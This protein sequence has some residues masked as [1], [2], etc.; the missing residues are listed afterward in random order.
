MDIFEKGTVLLTRVTNSDFKS[1]VCQKK[2]KNPT[3]ETAS[4]RLFFL[5][6]GCPRGQT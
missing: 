4:I 2:K 6:A 1:I 3:C 5:P